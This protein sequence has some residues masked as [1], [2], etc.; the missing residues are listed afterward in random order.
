MLLYDCPGQ[1]DDIWE[2]YQVQVLNDG[3]PTLDS[4][5]HVSGLNPAGLGYPGHDSRVLFARK[6]VVMLWDSLDAFL[7]TP[8]HQIFSI[9]GGPGLG[10][11]TEV[12][13]WACQKAVSQKVDLLWVHVEKRSLAKCV[14]S[15]Q[16]SL[17]TCKANKE[18]VRKIISETKAKIII[19]DGL[20]RNISQFDG[21][22]EFLPHPDSKHVVV[23]SL[24][25][26]VSPSDY[27]TDYST[28]TTLEL[29]PWTL[30]QYLSA[31]GSIDFL[32]SVHCFVLKFEE[33][34][35]QE[36]FE[37][38]KKLV[39]EKF[40]Y[41]GAS[42]RWM[43]NLSKEDIERE[44]SDCVL[45]VSN[46]NN[47][48]EFTSGARRGESQNHLLM[49]FSS[50]SMKQVFFVSQC[51]LDS[52]LQKWPE[53]TDI[54]YAYS[55]ARKHKNP[56]FLGWVV[57]FDFLD[58][59][60]TCLSL[61]SDKRKIMVS[62][63]DGNQEEWA[64]SGVTEFDAQ[65]A[66]FD[67][68]EWKPGQWMIPTCWNQAGYDAACIIE[69]PN[70]ALY[71]KAVQITRAKVHTL[72][73]NAFANLI[74]KVSSAIEKE[75]PGLEIVFLLP[76]DVPQPDLRPEGE[77]NLATVQ[78]GEGPGTWEKMKEVDQ[79]VFRRFQQHCKGCT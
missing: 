57:Q 30:E 19:V 10:K 21:D 77:G 14:E 75:I 65:A 36:I 76:M 61:S 41:A 34:S 63:L 24:S 8:N 47:L 37:D 50:G 58:Q 9:Y 53:G 33:L 23:S 72:N 64:V 1:K 31:C 4:W 52:C 56:A 60:K 12:W 2:A 49:S 29:E 16:G 22:V 3:K 43:F 45:K 71:L 5:F 73:V 27:G 48:M 38:A 26:N 39:K 79:V 78:V 40:Y 62:G 6:Q 74:R 67:A 70:G 28:F 55:L 7:S 59:I 54:K 46:F 17:F 42:A 32:K 25:A 11:S 68:N 44:I 13:A 51:A 35:D 20:R 66:G 69:K 18:Q 15:R